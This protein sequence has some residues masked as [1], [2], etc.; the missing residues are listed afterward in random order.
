MKKIIGRK[1]FIF[2]LVVFSLKI[3]DATFASTGILKYISYG[4][5]LLAI[6]ISLPFFFKYHGG[7]T[8]PIQLICVS[9]VI[10]IL[11]AKY[12]WG[13][14]FEYSPTTIPYLI[15]FVFFYLMNSK[16][17]IKTIE[18]IVLIYGVVYII[19]FLFQFT[20]NNVVYFG[21][22]E[23]FK[24]DRGIVR[25]NF[26]GAGVFILSCFIALNRVTSELGYKYCWLLFALTGI[27]IVILQ[28]TRQVIFFMILFYLIHFLRN[29]KFEYK[30][31]SILFFVFAA[32]IFFNS[33]SSI[34]NGLAR[35]QRKDIS[36]G[37]NYIRILNAK[38][39]LTH[40]TPNTASKIF[41]NGFF[42][43]NSKYGRTLIIL[44]ETYGYYLTDVG[45]VEVYITFGVFAILGYVL[46]FFKSLKISIPS[47]FYYLKYYLWFILFTCL[48]SD[49]LI[50][51]NFL[52]TTVF[53]L[54]CYQRL[55]EIDK[56]NT[57]SFEEK[58]AKINEIYYRDTSL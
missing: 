45:L 19:L 17:S 21:R 47:D 32:Y 9:V 8:L 22:Q 30:V 46:I 18:N 4:Y 52:I 26:P 48:T 2:L 53:V 31:V 33:D 7:F 11:M 58:S 35:Q 39:Y 24:L 20:H 27:V 12:T 5:M 13:Q 28:V 36:A 49:F 43:D 1:V 6:L 50:S 3:F 56:V 44:N 55:Y 41:G 40:F 15:W 54:Y 29:F 42:N 37:E 25:V 14:G 23:A 10:S 57:M 16:I 34:S 51:Y 38:Y